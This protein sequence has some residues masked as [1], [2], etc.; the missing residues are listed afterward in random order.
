MGE[1][2]KRWSV[3]WI[4]YYR[5]GR[6]HEESSHSRKKT[7]AERLLK[8]REGDV[9]RGVP[10][11]PRVG[12]LRFEEAA[13]DLITDYRVNGRRSLADVERRTKLHLDPFFGGRR[14]ASLTTSHVRAYVDARQAAGAANASINREL[15]ALKRMFNLA[16]AAGTLLHRPHIPMLA[17]DNTRSG[18]FERQEFE[19]VRSHLPTELRTVATFAYFTGWRIRSEV[20]PLEW[21]QVDR[22]VRRPPTFE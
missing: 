7:D 10:I 16:I 4:R 18:F 21:R 14:M 17:E 1:L 19:D 5:N 9:A 3:W 15:A 8:L 12:R 2:R 13:A 6:R 11:T 22:Q 20:L